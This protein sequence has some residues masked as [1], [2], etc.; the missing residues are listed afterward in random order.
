MA[1]ARINRTSVRR[2]LHHGYLARAT[3]PPI[4]PST[5]RDAIARLRSE[6]FDV[7]IIGGGVNGAGLARDLTLRSDVAKAPL[8][9][10]LVDQNHFA[11]GTSSRNSHLIHGGL[12]YLK[13]L[14]FH[15]VREALHERSVLL[16]IAPHLVDPLP[17]LLPISGL[18]QELY[19]NAGLLIYD[20]FSKHDA[21]PRHR[22]VSLDEVHQL[23]PGLAPPG[24]TAAAEYYDAEVRSARLVLENIF[25]SVAHGAACANYVA[26]TDHQRD[27]EIWRV[28]LRDHI[29]GESFETRA[30]S[31]VDAA[32]PWAHD[33]KPRLVRGSHIILP[34]LNASNH[35]IAYFDQSGRIIFFIPWGERRDRT[36]IG[37]TD[38]DH[39]GSPDDVHIS[40][41]EMR[42]L[43]G[44]AARVFPSSAS[45]DPL[46]SF[47]SLR[48]LLA[49]S[50][51]ATKAT[52]EHRIF[53]DPQGI[54]RITGGKFTTYRA[55]S[56]EAG[57][58]ITSCVA[59]ALRDVHATATTPL[60][61][62]STA[63]IAALRSEAPEL[64][65]RFFVETA[66]VEML[67]R[68]YGLFT[69]ALLEKL[70]P[71]RQDRLTRA[72]Q[73][74]ASEHEMAQHPADFFEV[75]TS[76]AYE[77]RATEQIL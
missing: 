71:D 6:T 76:L 32:G 22:R 42:Y 45:V 54:L 63:A 72:R 20:A 15:L 2:M 43:R 37:T 66:D 11:S 69:T 70:T 29:S 19:Y 67:I 35:A 47:S 30:R 56:E 38:V 64:A 17:F 75:S 52:R 10:A 51:S 36:L 13:M 34:R 61:S 46:A 53:F 16:N 48:P 18:S 68:Q 28:Q 25:E 26:V 9:V 59:P 62:N 4:T 24:M 39:D 7:L 21:F 77:G 55:M 58:L 27:G 1:P 3:Q 57:D 31:I 65:S 12:R 14:D 74:F 60:N 50:A 40:P 33:P 49:S 41:D 73:R 5:R 23:E 8:G 44:T